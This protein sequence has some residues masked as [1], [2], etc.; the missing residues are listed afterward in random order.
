MKRHYTGERLET[1]IY[2][3][4]TIKHLHRYALA[5]NIVNDKDVL[6]IASGEGYGSHLISSKAKYV[7]GVDIDEDT[8]KNSSKKY[9]KRNLEFILGSTS[10]IPLKD[11]SVDVV[12]SFETIEHHDEHELMMLEIKRVLRPE[13]VLLISSPDKYFYSDLRNY[14][15]K[16][17]VKELYKKE[18]LD[19]ISKH[20][21]NYY[22]YSQ[23]YV[24]GSSLIIEDIKRKDFEFYSGDYMGVEKI[25]STPDYLIAICSDSGLIK[26][27]DSIFEGKQLIENDK[28]E[29][30][31]NDVYKSNSYKVGHIILYPLKLIKRLI[32]Q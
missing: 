17:H 12:I 22:L 28:L 14:H 18:L 8:I 32:K 1:H 10:K 6:D 27:S 30:R 5:L 3:D 26:L 31:L 19:L 2:N 9:K 24:N 13:G 21:V 15:N 4:N 23:S 20:F 16:F 29:K 7:Y 11:N 25:S